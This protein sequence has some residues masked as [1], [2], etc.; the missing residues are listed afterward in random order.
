MD[1]T[2]GIVSSSQE[3]QGSHWAR[4]YA[5]KMPSSSSVAVEDNTTAD[6]EILGEVE[7]KDMNIQGSDS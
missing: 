2:N 6:G 3:F 4:G 1:T 5:S 7:V